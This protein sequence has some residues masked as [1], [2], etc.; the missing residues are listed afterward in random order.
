MEQQEC[1]GRLIVDGDE[2]TTTESDDL[3]QTP[4]CYGGLSE[5]GEFFF[6]LYPGDEDDETKWRFSLTSA[7]IDAIAKGATTTLDLWMCDRCG[8]SDR[9]GRIEGSCR[10]C[11][12]SL[13]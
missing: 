11:D 1:S 2:S 12:A 3:L 6:C 4:F 7:Q 8:S 5:T 9:Y 13:F 10:S